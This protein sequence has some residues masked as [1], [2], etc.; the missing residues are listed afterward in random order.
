MIAF[1][2]ALKEE[3]EAVRRTWGL[4]PAGSVQGFELETGRGTVHFCSGIG[5][6]RMERVVSL[7]YKTF[8]PSLYVLVGYSVG[9]VEDLEVGD[10]ICDERSS[11][12]LTHRCRTGRVATCGFL[13]TASQKRAFAQKHPKCLA[14]DLETEAFLA[15]VPTDAG[16]LVVRAVSDTVD[17]DLPLNFEELTTHQGF[18]DVRAIALKVA[19]RPFLLPKL[20]KLSRDAGVATR[21][22]ANFLSECREELEPHQKVLGS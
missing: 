1:F 19:A 20:V 9:L 11:P 6:D 8:R 21:A 4:S 5:A 17:T 12:V 15:A 13:N 22:L 2:T 7:A 10:L 14:A 18:P 16:S 3:R